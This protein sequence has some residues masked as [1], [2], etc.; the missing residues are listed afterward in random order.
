MLSDY[1]LSICLN[2]KMFA[3][4]CVMVVIGVIFSCFLYDVT[5]IKSSALLMLYSGICFTSDYLVYLFSGNII[6]QDLT[7]NVSNAFISLVP[8]TVSQIIIFFVIMLCCRKFKYKD[9]DRVDNGVWLRL[10]VIPLFTMATVISILFFF[11]DGTTA[12]QKHTLIFITVGMLLVNIYVFYMFRDILVNESQ[13]QKDKLL[14]ERAEQ[15]EKMYQF[16]SENYEK[17][18]K[19]EHEFRNQLF[20]LWN[21]IE[22]GENAQAHD[23]MLQY[24][25]EIDLDANLFDTNNVIINTIL[26]TKYKMAK[27]QNVLF[28]VQIG[29]L[30]MIP[31]QNRDMVV[32]L[33]NIIDNALEACEKVKDKKKYIKLKV[34]KEHEN[35]MISCENSF[36][37]IVYRD[38]DKYLTTKKEESESH[39]IGICNIKEVALKYNGDCI[40]RTDEFKFRIIV[41]VPL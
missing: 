37:G 8:G 1:I 26:N 20:I 19:R 16:I 32:I 15:T 35:L 13:L 21:L 41:S 4:A 17:Q 5:P 38:K 14:L 18:R 3:K 27:K 7:D 10:F 40:I 24:T 39:G 28:V 23:L 33:T 34:Q 29:D 11:T 30:S 36:D 9:M 12:G 6:A 2:H 22:K 31:I 25:E